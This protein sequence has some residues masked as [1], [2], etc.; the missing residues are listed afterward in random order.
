M[1]TFCTIYI[2]YL[3]YICSLQFLTTQA[4]LRL[5]SI[6]VRLGFGVIITWATPCTSSYG[7][8]CP[9]LCT[10]S[11]WLLWLQEAYQRQAFE[12]VM[13]KKDNRHSQLTADIVAVEEQLSRLTII[14]M[15]NKVAASAERRVSR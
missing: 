7:L 14:E 1:Y 5:I 13:K 10:L 9:N 8:E 3:L 2:F 15:N 4:I 12:M 11:S 6:D